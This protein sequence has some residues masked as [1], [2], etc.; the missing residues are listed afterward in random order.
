[1]PAPLILVTPAGSEPPRLKLK[2]STPGNATQ[3]WPA[4]RR[5]LN[6]KGRISGVTRK[7]STLD[8][9]KLTPDDWL[10]LRGVQNARI[11]FVQTSEFAPLSYAGTRQRLQ[12]SP[13]QRY[14]WPSSACGFLYFHSPRTSV[15]APLT[16]LAA[17]LRFR[18]A[19]SPDDLARAFNGGTSAVDAAHMDVSIDRGGYAVPWSIP[20]LSLRATPTSS[21]IWN[22]LKHDNLVTGE[23]L[24]K[25]DKLALQWNRNAR[26]TQVL[27]DVAQCWTL[28]L[29]QRQN[30]LIV[31]A[32][33]KIYTVELF[34]VTMSHHA[35]PYVEGKQGIA[36]VRFELDNGGRLVLRTLRYLVPPDPSI[37]ADGI[38]QTEGKLL[39][40]YQRAWGLDRWSPG[41]PWSAD[42][43]S[44][45]SPVSIDALA[46]RYSQSS[47]NTLDP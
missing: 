24:E 12:A 21:A 37:V 45:L 47:C 36:S 9:S 14:P 31:I 2:L 29:G 1:M 17:S 27:Y 30:R 41:Q 46:Q 28:N 34:Q 19:A 33:E 44:L 5:L 4:F 26:K 6:T 3:Q 8:P 20:L 32:G 25:V 22:Q 42:P 39:H 7:V 40:R 18:T 11:H 16:E 43:S 23:T 15:G 13:H 38:G 35:R 10:D